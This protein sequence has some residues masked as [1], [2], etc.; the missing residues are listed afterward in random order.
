MTKRILQHFKLGHK[1]EKDDN[2]WK[3]TDK[4]DENRTPDILFIERCLDLLKPGGRMAIILPDG[5][6]GNDSYEYVR[7]FIIDNADI[8]AI[9]DCPVESFLPSTDTKTSLLILKKKKDI[10]IPQ[11]FDTFMAIAKTCGHDRRGKEIL[12][13][14]ES[15]NFIEEDGKFVSD[16]DFEEIM[17]RLTEHVI[18]KN[19]YD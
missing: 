15:G 16:N 9:I 11:T 2:V 18:A 14:D 4:V 3:V 7:Q 1:W 8:V 5:I 19:I 6:L 17:R 12:K 13:R 10:D